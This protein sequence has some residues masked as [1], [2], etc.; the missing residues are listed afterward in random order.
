MGKASRKKHLLRQRGTILPQ[1]GG[2][3]L[4][5]ALFDLVEPLE[6][7][8]F[9]HEEIRKLL[10]IGVVAWNI[11]V[12]PNEERAEKLMAFLKDMPSTMDAIET[13]LA[14]MLQEG[15]SNTELPP[16]MTLLEL[17]SFL[18]HRKDALFPNDNRLILQFEVSETP[19]GPH[20]T[21]GSTP[22]IRRPASSGH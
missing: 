18:V 16:T 5:E 20:L 17:V 22:Y 8:K 10:S 3:K 19:N 14:E 7:D 13:E 9:S 1:S 21:V 4:S 12:F 15:R 2:I 6:L 11:A